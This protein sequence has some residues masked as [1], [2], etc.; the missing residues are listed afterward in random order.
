MKAFTQKKSAY[1]KFSMV[2][3]FALILLAGSSC[4]KKS[5]EDTTVSFHLHNPISGEVL[6][7]VKVSV[8]RVKIKKT[9]VFNGSVLGPEFESELVDSAYTDDNG[10]ASIKFKAYGNQKYWYEAYASNSAFH[11]MYMLKQ[12][13]F[14]H[15]V[16]KDKVNYYEYQYTVPAIFNLHIKNVN[17]LDEN[18][19]F[20][21][22]YKFE[23]NTNSSD[24][25]LWNSSFGHKD[26][27]QS[28]E[29]QFCDNFIYEY[30]VIRNGSSGP[31]VRDTF[32]INPYSIDTLKIYY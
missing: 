12:P 26:N 19:E 3:M 31:M 6:S 11:G 16:E 7:G 22:R 25:D 28:I 27:F 24:W 29:N 17:Y 23:Y 15:Q 32:F 30:Q 21:F 8:Y 9:T 5:R 18:D 10:K 1:S 20:K 13:S 2:F 14:G 4:K